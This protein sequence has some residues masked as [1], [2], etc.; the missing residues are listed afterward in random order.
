ME[1]QNGD[2]N[3]VEQLAVVLDGSAAREEDDDLL[4]EVL[5]QE[6]K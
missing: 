5:P 3:V 6:G 1:I 2:V 4:F